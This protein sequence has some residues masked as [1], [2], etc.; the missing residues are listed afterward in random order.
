M[1]EAYNESSSFPSHIAI[2]RVGVGEP[3]PAETDLKNGSRFSVLDP[4]RERH[5]RRR[6]ASKVCKVS[7]AAVDLPVRATASR[8]VKRSKTLACIAQQFND[9]IQGCSGMT[10]GPHPSLA[11]KTAKSWAVSRSLVFSAKRCTTPGGSNQLCPAANIAGR[12]ASQLRPYR[13]FQNIGRYRAGMPVPG[14][15]GAR[16]KG[17]HGRGDRHA[18]HVLQSRAGNHRHARCRPGGS[19]VSFDERRQGGGM[20]GLTSHECAGNQGGNTKRGCSRERPGWP[21]RQPVH[22]SCRQS[23]SQPSRCRALPL[24]TVPSS[25]AT[26]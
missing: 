19:S 2:I 25:S 16:R 22:R 17:H 23:S 14:R 6:R 1:P 12:I 3:F 21:T 20:K 9:S 24:S 10:K 13:A 18:R 5:E 26:L 8:D 11:T 7:K 15:V 4:F